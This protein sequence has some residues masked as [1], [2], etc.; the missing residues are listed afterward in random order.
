MYITYI[1]KNKPCFAKCCQSGSLIKPL[2]F[3]SNSGDSVQSGWLILVSGVH[4]LTSE[5]HNFTFIVITSFLE[6]PE[7]ILCGLPCSQIRHPENLLIVVKITS[8]YQ[9]FLWCF[10]Y[11]TQAFID[12]L[13]I[14]FDMVEFLLLPKQT[15]FDEIVNI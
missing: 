8:H 4:G 12:N 7:A 10:S 11:C 1:L 15:E 13:S 5:N 3:S 2:A 6:K 14:T 9:N